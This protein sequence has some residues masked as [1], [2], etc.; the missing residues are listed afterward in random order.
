MEE[1][2][3]V[4]GRKLGSALQGKWGFSCHPAPP[5]PW[6]VVDVGT[7]TPLTGWAC[8]KQGLV[9]FHGLLEWTWSCFTLLWFRAETQGVWSVYSWCLST[10]SRAV[11]Q[12]AD[13][14]LLDDPLRAVD[15]GVSRHLFEQWVC[16][17][18]ISSLLPRNPVENTGKRVQ[19][20]LCAS[21]DVARSALVTLSPIPPLHRR[22]ILEKSCIMVRSGQENTAGVSSEWR[23]VGSVLEGVR[24]W[25]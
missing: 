24:D 17:C 16:S 13:I 4:K 1:P 5:P 2:R 23:T 25:W 3:W 8:V 22:S 18:F 15:A 19:E 14:Y 6:L 12:D 21:G 20:S 11:Y 9:S 10:F 7:Q